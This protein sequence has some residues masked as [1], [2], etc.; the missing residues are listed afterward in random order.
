MF[1]HGYL[2]AVTGSNAAPS[3]FTTRLSVL[4]G[5]IKGLVSPT[6]KLGKIMHLLFKRS[7][8]ATTAVLPLLRP[9]PKFKLWT[10]LELE[11]EEQ[12]VLDH[13]HF[14][15]SV[16]IEA[17]EAELLR[18]AAYVGIAVFVF[19]VLFFFWSLHFAALFFWGAIVSGAAAFFYYDKYRETIFVKDL[20]HGRYFT[21]GS[22]VDL[23]RKEAW[24]ET[25]C[26]Y[27]RQVMES[28][29]HWDGTEA[30]PIEA[31]DKD[32]AKQL[33]IKGV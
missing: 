18:K 31:M 2:S 7:Q 28:A 13:Y 15:D 25:V 4:T 17:F 26:A 16:L 33:M 19:F 20:L 8:T 3:H 23:A 12:T 10:K 5:L 11:P 1:A 14:D 21:C 29:K 24:L 9:R 27:L 30:I 22:V 6:E 32:M